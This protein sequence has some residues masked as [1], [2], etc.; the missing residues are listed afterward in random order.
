MAIIARLFMHGR[1]PGRYMRW[2]QLPSGASATP[3]LHLYYESRMLWSKLR[4]WGCATDVALGLNTELW[5][6]VNMVRAFPP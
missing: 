5:Q 6:H 3:T 1:H 4:G 2:K